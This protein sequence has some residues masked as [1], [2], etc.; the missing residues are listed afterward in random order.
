MDIEII[1]DDSKKV[2]YDNYVSL[3]D[4]TK[5]I[6]NDKYNKY[7]AVKINNKIQE[8]SSHCLKEGDKVEFLDI[9]DN[10][11]HKIYV[12]T[13]CLIYIK[14]CRDI[15]KNIDISI[16]HSLNKGLYTEILKNNKHYILNEEEIKKIINRMQEI[17]D[18]N[19]PINKIMMNKNDAIDIFTKQN[20]HDKADLLRQMNKDVVRVYEVDGYY[21]SFYGYL[22]P[23]TNCIDK[24]DLRLFNP[25]I[26]LNFPTKESNY[27]LPEYIEHKKLSK[28]FSEAEKWGKIMDVGNVVALN[29]KIDENTIDDMIRINEA[30]H[31]KKIAYIA[32]EIAHDKDIKIVLIAGP[33]SSGKTTFAQRLSIQLR[34][35]GKKTYALSLD[36]YFLDRELTPKDENGKHDFESINALDLELF[37]SQLVSLMKCQ[38]VNIPVYNFVKGEREYTRTPVTLTEEH[39]IIIEGIHG[40]N[41]KLTQ[42]IPHK[43]K[44]K[45]YISALTQL[46]IDNHNRISTTDVRLIRRIVR[47]NAYRGN[48]IHRTLELWDDVVIGNEKYI[49]PFQ[50][51]ADAMF[52]SALVYELGVLKKYAIPLLEEIN[53]ND[54]FYSEK[55]R[56]LNFLSYFHTI[57]DEYA[58]PNT[59]ILREFIGGSCF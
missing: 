26:I 12:R 20:L 21:D 46:N 54:K 22:A 44:F 33:S 59:S 45:I 19:L 28:V 4:L 37:N 14:A 16:E 32:D 35:N 9:K 8:L 3:Y 49:F 18:A 40:L 29:K 34:V 56:L 39:I 52:N 43:N 24:F 15:L 48:K 23:N 7:L 6:Y 47:D 31:E 38:T 1:S 53:E 51:N 41:E 10:D 13:L 55:V 30:L 27:E 58:I 25:G 50:E 17:V 57:E 11:G 5:H 2:K 42:S 36:D